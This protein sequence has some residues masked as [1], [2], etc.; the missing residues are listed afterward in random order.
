MDLGRRRKFIDMMISSLKPNYMH[1]LNDY[2]RVLEQRNNYLK[3]IKKENKSQ[4][5]L[6]IFDE[7]LADLSYRIFEYRNQYLEKFAE[8]IQET[9]STAFCAKKSPISFPDGG[10][11]SYSGE[12]RNLSP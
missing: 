5:L 3:Q 4:E 1:L 12:K 10:I 8:K 11:I 7:Q 9:H 6:E 2:N